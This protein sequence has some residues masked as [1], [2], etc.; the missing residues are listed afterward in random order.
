MSESI[1][2]RDIEGFIDS[3]RCAT[4]DSKQH[5]GEKVHLPIL[6]PSGE[7]HRARTYAGHMET[8]PFTEYTQRQLM[9]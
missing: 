3:L 4:V 9:I 7:R 8:C 6:F 5:P 2:G 1:D